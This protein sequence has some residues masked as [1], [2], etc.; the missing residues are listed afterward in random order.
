LILKTIFIEIGADVGDLGE[1]AAGDAKRR[2]AERLADGEADEALAGD[3]A[4]EEQQD[5]EHD[6]QLD[7]DQGHA[8][9]HAGLEGHVIAGPRLATE[10]W[11]RRPRLL[12]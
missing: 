3:L 12:A 8:D 5:D 11:R 9:R 7:A 10:R 6:Q 2:G 1:D 4:G